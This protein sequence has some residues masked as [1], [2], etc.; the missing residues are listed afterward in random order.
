[1]PR[2]FIAVDLPDE[3]TDQVARL[4]VGLPAVRWCMADRLH[5][6]VR[7]IG[8][9]PHEVFYDIGQG[10]GAI[11][12]R[13]F[14]IRLK[15]VGLFPPR[16][17]PHTLWVGVSDSEALGQLKRRIDRIVEHA[18]VEPE[19]RRFQPH[20]TIGR[21]RDSLPESRFGSWLAGRALFTSSP[22]V[23]SGFSLYMSHLRPEGPLYTR[24]ASYD[25]VS[26]VM[27]RV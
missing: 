21:V 22:F 11:T 18:G 12:L 17:A 26:G 10:L 20:V 14:E 27:E 25:F 9:V 19:R 3:V 8:E 7:F 1:M 15:S 13:P 16:G 6:T 24:E 4:C 23:V 5:L 2:L